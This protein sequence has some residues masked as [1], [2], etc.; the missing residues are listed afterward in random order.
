MSYTLSEPTQ[1]S[2]QTRFRR[3]GFQLRSRRLPFSHGPFIHSA[4]VFEVL[5][6]RFSDIFGLDIGF[7]ERY[8]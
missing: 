5:M 3:H 7:H 2:G 4:V 6:H 1:T 8:T